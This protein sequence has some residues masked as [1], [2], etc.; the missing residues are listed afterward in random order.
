MQFQGLGNDARIHQLAVAE[1]SA[2]WQKP[3]FARKIMTKALLKI[4]LSLAVLSSTNLKVYAAETCARSLQGVVRVDC[5]RQRTLL[6]G[7]KIRNAVAQFSQRDKEISL[8]ESVDL[9]RTWIE[10]SYRYSDRLKDMKRGLEKI[11]GRIK[12][13]ETE[14]LNYKSRDRYR[15]QI[16]TGVSIQGDA[17]V[18]IDDPMGTSVSVGSKEELSNQYKDELRT[19]NKIIELIDREKKAQAIRYLRL[20]IILKNRET[21]TGLVIP[22]DIR[23]ISRTRLELYSEINQLLDP[24]QPLASEMNPD[25]NYLVWAKTLNLKDSFR[26]KIMRKF[27]LDTP[28][29]IWTCIIDKSENIHIKR[30]RMLFPILFVSGTLASFSLI[31]GQLGKIHDQTLDIVQAIEQKTKDPEK[32]KKDLEEKKKLETEKRLVAE[33]KKIAEKSNTWVELRDGFKT[34]LGNFPAESATLFS[35][36]HLGLREDLEP[37]GTVS[38]YYFEVAKVIDLWWLRIYEGYSKEDEQLIYGV[39]GRIDIRTKAST[40]LDRFFER[41]ENP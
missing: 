38:P 9:V 6:G 3:F 33:A 11:E 2:I 7:E 39:K 29:R 26:R 36:Y 34:F 27:Y 28:T 22:N 32:Q 4:L 8:E 13:L 16:P 37:D 35:E 20:E 24:Q 41:L 18:P 25:R 19:K 30:K 12:I 10:E 23:G 40:S 17:V 31:A 21:E 15:L 5:A 14:K 1:A